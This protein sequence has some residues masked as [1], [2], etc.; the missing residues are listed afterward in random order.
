MKYIILFYLSVAFASGDLLLQLD[1]IRNAKGKLALLVFSSEKGF[2]DDSRQAT[3][4][5]ELEAKKGR[6]IFKLTDLKGGEYAFVVLHDENENLQLDKNLIGYPKE[7]V[8][9]SN[10]EK[11]AFPKFAKALVKEPKSPIQLKM[12]YP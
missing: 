1:G 7:G 10:Y 11:L 12:L 3:R 2:P 5:I 8:A 9:I 4:K 6:L